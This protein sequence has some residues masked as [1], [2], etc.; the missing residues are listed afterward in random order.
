MGQIGEKSS[1]FALLA[2]AKNNIDRA[3]EHSLIYA[4]IQIDDPQGA[5]API[6]DE[7]AEP[8]AKRAALIALD[9]MDHGALTSEEVIPFLRA[10]DPQVKQAANWIV[11]HHPD[12]AGALV[13]HVRTSLQQPTLPPELR[14]QI[15]KFLPNPQMQELVATAVSESRSIEAKTL[16]LDAIADSNLKGIPAAWPEAI[17]RQ[18]QEGDNRI[19]HAA[20]RAAKS[21]TTTNHIDPEIEK[22]ASQIAKDGTREDDLRLEVLGLRPA[23]SVLDAPAFSFALTHLEAS[24]PAMQRINAASVL[25]R[26]TLTEEQLMMLTQRLPEIGPLEITRLLPAYA[27][28][29]TEEI[30]MGLVA[31]LKESKALTAISAENLRNRFAIYPE[32]VR[33]A[34]GELLAKLNSTFAEKK[35]RLDDMEAS[36]PVGDSHRGHLIFNGPRAACN[37]CHAVGYLGGQ[38]GPDLTRVGAIRTQRD[39]LEAILFPSASFVRGFE[40]FMIFTKDGEQYSGLVRKEASDS[41]VLVSGPSAE[42]RILR[43]DIKEMRPGTVSVMPEG[44]EQ[45]LSKQEL[46][47]LLAFLKALK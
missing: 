16:L 32:K 29:P 6:S 46:S 41:L 22:V 40:P 33:T 34:A 10:P 38:V 31:A 14:E 21:I 13:A 23:G 19:A 5:R 47:D 26:A 20:I 12:W 7:R 4:L 37:T 1:V 44:L 18:M 36:L 28:H 43:S 15:V 17:A 45:Q 35:K 30:G 39:L 11:S 9:Q 25:G 2:A 27:A 8:A 42:Q 3:F 24:R